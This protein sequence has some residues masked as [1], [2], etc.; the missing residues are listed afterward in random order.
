[1]K[2]YRVQKHPNIHSV[3]LLMSAVSH[4]DCS[5]MTVVVVSIQSTHQTSTRFLD[6]YFSSHSMMRSILFGVQMKQIMQWQHHLDEFVISPM[7]TRTFQTLI[8]NS[9]QQCA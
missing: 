8:G 1:M 9:R 3:D 4:Y 7:L 2:H 5:L 6:N